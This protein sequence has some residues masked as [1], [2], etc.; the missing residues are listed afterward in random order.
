[1]RKWS[2]WCLPITIKYSG[3]RILTSGGEEGAWEAPKILSETRFT[4]LEII[5]SVS[6]T[7]PCF[8]CLA[9]IS[10]SAPALGTTLLWLLLSAPLCTHSLWVLS[11]PWSGLQPFLHLRH[12][13]SL[14]DGLRAA[15][16]VCQGESGPSPR[17][18]WVSEQLK[19]RKEAD[20]GGVVG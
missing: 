2:T 18:L 9:F 8:D 16:G 10:K 12:H 19:E 5:S 17:W 11:S 1:M 15:R 4:A 14:L 20:S 13:T 7:E 6:S 3:G